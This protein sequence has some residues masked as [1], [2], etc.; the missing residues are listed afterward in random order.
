[1][2]TILVPTDF[3]EYAHIALETAINLARHTQARVLVLHVL[4]PPRM[5]KSSHESIFT[6]HELESKYMKYLQDIADLKLKNELEKF[7]KYY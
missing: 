6:D 4:E 2:K 3:S 7:V 1:M 5:S